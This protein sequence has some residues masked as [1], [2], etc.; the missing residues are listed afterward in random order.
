M[1]EEIWVDVTEAAEKTGYH[2]D[3]LLRLMGAQWK[4][5]E[6]EREVQMRK[7]SAGYIIWFPTL[8][9]YLKEHGY[10]PYGK[11]GRQES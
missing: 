7:L 2:R 6:G 10:G 1:T 8:V 3:Y 5:P 9:S 4:K 11:R